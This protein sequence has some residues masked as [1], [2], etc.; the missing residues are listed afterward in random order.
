MQSRSTSA[1]SAESGGIRARPRRPT[2][3]ARCD[4][5][6]CFGAAQAPLPSGSTGTTRHRSVRA[7]PRTEINSTAAG[8]A[9]VKASMRT[10]PSRATPGDRGQ[11][12]AADAEQ[13]PRA[14]A[15]AGQCRDQ[16]RAA[17]PHGHPVGDDKAA[18]PG[19]RGAQMIGD[20]ST[21]GADDD[22]QVSVAGQRELQGGRDHRADAPRCGR[23][24]PSCV[25]G[26]RP[27]RLRSRAVPAVPDREPVAPKSI[28]SPELWTAARTGP[29]TISRSTPAERA[30]DARASSTLVPVD[31]STAPVFH[32][33]PRRRVSSR[34]AGPD[35]QGTPVRRSRRPPRRGSPVARRRAG[36]RRWRCDGPAR[37][38]VRRCAFRRRWHRPAGSTDRGPRR[39]SHPSRTHRTA[40]T[41]LRP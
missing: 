10:G 25:T 37:R 6:A 2:M 18:G 36:G 13:H 29:R 17:G 27:A 9:A 8:S 22:D 5:A 40:G 16:N 24:R 15:V 11:R 31:A 4:V 30:S 35:A 21:G 39:P 23:R 32:S 34:S 33:L 41:V 19:D 7:T 14:G 26:R 20:P 12:V 28:S 38:P 1:P 3:A